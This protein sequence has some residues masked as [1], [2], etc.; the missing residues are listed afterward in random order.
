VSAVG[1]PSDMP[2][3]ETNA[4]PPE[5]LDVGD[6][7]VE[8]VTKGKADETPLLALTGVTLVVGAFVAL[9][10]GLSLLVYFLV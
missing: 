6:G 3:P 4:L 8:K 10:A 2:A 5:Q 9:V 7:P 1:Y